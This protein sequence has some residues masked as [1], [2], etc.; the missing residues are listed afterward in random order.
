M[1]AWVTVVDN[2]YFA[3]T[4]KDGKFTIKNVPPGKY[5]IAALHRKAAPAGKT[6]SAKTAQRTAV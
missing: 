3:V 2:P 1:F 5:K 6:A 4:D